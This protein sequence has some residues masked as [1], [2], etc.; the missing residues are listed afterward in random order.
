[1]SAVPRILHHIWIGPENP[2][3]KWMQTWRSHNPEWEYVLWNNNSLFKGPIWRNA[4]HMESLYAEKKWSAVADLMRYEILLEQGGFVAPAD[5]ICVRSINEFVDDERYDAFSAYENEK[6]RP[7]LVMPLLAASRGNEF[8][9]HLVS[10]LHAQDSL[11]DGEAWQLTGNEFMQDAI[12]ATQYN[13]IKIWPSITMIPHHYTG[14]KGQGDA[15]TFATHE[16][17]S[18]GAYERY[19]KE[20]PCLH[21]QE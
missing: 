7:G 19:N 5:S 17:G 12:E 6:V 3:L 9:H 8:A 14:E 21:L 16:W 13:G 11:L 2:P 18:K 15:P 20:N 1:M 10:S 4:D